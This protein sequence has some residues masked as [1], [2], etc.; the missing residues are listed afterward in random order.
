MKNKQTKKQATDKKRNKLTTAKK[1]DI[2]FLVLMSAQ[3][4][5]SS[6]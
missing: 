2:I 6:L 1:K 3:I 4:D 5:Q